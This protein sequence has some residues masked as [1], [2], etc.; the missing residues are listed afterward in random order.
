MSDEAPTARARPHGPFASFCLA[1]RA[2][3]QVA[4]KFTGGIGNKLCGKGREAP[5]AGGGGRA[6]RPR[7]AGGRPRALPQ[8][9]GA[10]G[11]GLVSRC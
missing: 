4:Q 11:R 9:K 5:A 2:W 8:G 6:A 1:A 7:R 3:C 10:G